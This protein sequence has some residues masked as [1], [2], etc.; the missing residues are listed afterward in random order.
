MASPSEQRPTD[1]REQPGETEQPPRPDFSRRGSILALDYGRK[2]IGAAVSDPQRRF[3]SP[4]EVYNPQ[5]TEHDARHYRRLVAEH[6]VAWIV[7]GLPV[8]ASGS[9]SAMSAEARRFALKLGRE[10]DRPVVM[11]DERYTSQ[12]ADDLLR[13]AGLRASQRKDQRDKLAAYLMLQAYLDAGCPT[14]LEPPRELDD[15]SA[16]SSNT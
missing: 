14:R 12:E 7:V 5:S 8:H 13:E 15:G 11:I 10:V 16:R 1:D 4:L 3:S 2:R 9:E 6:E